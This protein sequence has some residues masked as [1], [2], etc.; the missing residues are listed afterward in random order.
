VSAYNPAGRAEVNRLGRQLQDLLDRY[1]A[2][3]RDPT[4]ELDLRVDAA[5]FV[6]VRIC[7][8][9]EQSLITLTTAHAEGRSAPTVARFVGSWMSRT[10]N[11]KREALVEFARR[12]EHAWGDELDAYFDQIDPSD[13]FNSL[14]QTRN[15]IAHGLSTGINRDTLIRHFSLAVD[16]VDWFTAKLDPPP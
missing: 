11:P 14:V 5:K 4:S 10:Q 7:G 1:D 12:F 13:T 9:V 16:V 3:V 2:F 8:Y 15:D 6:C